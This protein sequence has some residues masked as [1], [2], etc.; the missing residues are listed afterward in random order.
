LDTTEAVADGVTAADGPDEGPVP[1]GLEA[2]TVNVYEVPLLS[3][4][5]LAVVGAGD[6]VT[7]VG[8]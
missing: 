8:D 7:V 1:A 2:V 6:P 5:T 3:P 4:V